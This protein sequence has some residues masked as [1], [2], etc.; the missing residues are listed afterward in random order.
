MIIVPILLCQSFISCHVC[1][2]MV[3]IYYLKNFRHVIFAPFL[4]VSSI[5]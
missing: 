2:T 4:F 1:F 3:N 5:Y